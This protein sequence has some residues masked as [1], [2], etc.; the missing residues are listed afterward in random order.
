MLSLTYNVINQFMPFV[1]PKP[2]PVI[3]SDIELLVNVITYL[4]ML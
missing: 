2:V 1:P 3:T 4:V